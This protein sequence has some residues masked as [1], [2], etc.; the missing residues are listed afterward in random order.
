MA[1]YEEIVE[2]YAADDAEREILE[3]I[4][5]GAPEIVRKTQDEYSRLFVPRL[6]SLQQYIT[7]QAMG[8]QSPEAA[9]SFLTKVQNEYFR[10]E[11]D[12]SHKTLEK[13]CSDVLY[14]MSIEDIRKL[15]DHIRIDM[16]HL[17]AK[18]AENNPVVQTQMFRL[19]TGYEPAEAKSIAPVSFDATRSVGLSPKMAVWQQWKEQEYAGREAAMLKE[20]PDIAQLAEKWKSDPKSLP[21]ADKIKVLNAFHKVHAETYGY[22]PV[23]IESATGMGPLMGRAIDVKRKDGGHG[24]IVMNEGALRSSDFEKAKRLFLH[25][26]DHIAQSNWHNN[27]RNIPEDDPRH[28]YIRRWAAFQHMMEPQGFGGADNTLAGFSRLQFI[29]YHTMPHEIHA[30]LFHRETPG[31]IPV[32]F[33]KL[34]DDPAYKP[35]CLPSLCQ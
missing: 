12:E 6:P 24:I 31:Q 14:R 20:R 32:D 3:R 35:P 16:M 30:F 18:D 15:P 27:W 2:G 4:L 9:H 19:A 28:D 13:A 7:E 5:A 11:P 26:S 1:T 10:S 29:M 21:D 25:E 22:A 34:Q 17:L 33:R 8:K 23:P